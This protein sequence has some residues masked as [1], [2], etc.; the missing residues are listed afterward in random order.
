MK[1]VGDGKV[2]GPS[3]SGMAEASGSGMELDRPGTGG[4]GMVTPPEGNC[5]IVGALGSSG[6]RNP[7][8]Y[9]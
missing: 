6:M 3:I 4:W 5:G 1:V 2:G 8:S 7:S 9:A